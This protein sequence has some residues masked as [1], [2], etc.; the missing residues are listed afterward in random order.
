LPFRF[1]YL[2]SFKYAFN[3]SDTPGITLEHRLYT[4][5]PEEQEQVLLAFERSIQHPD[6]EL[7]L[8]GYLPSRDAED[9]KGTQLSGGTT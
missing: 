2:L 8:S 7:K 6:Q 5:F 9:S 1:K 4:S 3:S